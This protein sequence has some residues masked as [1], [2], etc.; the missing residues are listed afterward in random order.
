MKNAVFYFIL[1]I[2]IFIIVSCDNDSSG[3]SNS[4]PREKWNIELDE[5]AGSGTI[6]LEQHPDS[7]ITIT[8]SVEYDYYE[9]YKVTSNITNGIV[10]I[11]GF[12]FS[13]FAEGTAHDYAYNEDSNFQLILT[14][15]LI[16]GEGYGFY[17]STFSA[18]DWE[19]EEGSWTASLI[20]GE[21][22][23]AND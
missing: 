23:T 14:G 4:N 15:T 19:D 17:E 12:A 7:T 21:G 22:I 10:T 16:N 11:D 20:D 13:C 6:T 9:R 18:F 1:L 3:P 5:G 2:S 8:G